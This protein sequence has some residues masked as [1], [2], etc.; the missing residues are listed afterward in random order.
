MV[1]LIFVLI[2]MGVMGLLFLWAVYASYQRQKQLEAL[3]QRWGF[4]YQ[5]QGDRRLRSAMGQFKL[6]HQGRQGNLSH[7]IQ[8]ED[9]GALISIFD[10]SYRTGTHDKSHIHRQTVVLVES[11]KMNLPQFF[12]APENVFHRIGG[13][14]GYQDVDFPDYPEF[15]RRF[16]LKGRDEGPLRSLFN[17]ETI[18]LFESL[19]KPTCE[20]FGPCFI[21][22]HRHKVF[23]PQG[24][25]SLRREA[26]EIFYKFAKFT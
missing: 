14:F 12:L 16:L 8:G 19:A 1:D 21:Y 9:G 2:V 20:G 15:S 7:L 18:P 4:S 3:A 11:T 17:Y 10:Y 6:F 22:Y 13:L 23:P 25:R 24:W 5:P 26:T